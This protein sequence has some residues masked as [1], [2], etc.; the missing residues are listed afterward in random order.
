MKRAL[1]A[2]A[3]V[4]CL[5]VSAP[6][7][8]AADSFVFSNDLKD[9]L[10]LWLENSSLDFYKVVDFASADKYDIAVV[11]D[12]NRIRMDFPNITYDSLMGGFKGF[13]SALIDEVINLHTDNAPVRGTVTADVQY[14]MLYGKGSEVYEWNNKTLNVVGGS[15]LATIALYDENSERIHV[16]DLLLTPAGELITPI[17]A[18]ALLLGSGLAGI[19]VLRRKLA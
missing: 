7:A 2:L 6:L 18:A 14:F 12:R 15:V 19:A 8:S 13:Q 17:P 1:T 11:F 10:T 9:N 5:G 4:L 16:Q 3:L